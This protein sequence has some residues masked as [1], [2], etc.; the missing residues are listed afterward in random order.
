[1]DITKLSFE[2]AIKEWNVGDKVRVVSTLEYGRH[3]ALG[4]HF[5]WDNVMTDHKG[6]T[7]M[8]ESFN[9]MYN[10]IILTNGT[11]RF[12]NYFW[13]AFVL[14]KVEDT[15]YFINT[16][17]HLFYLKNKEVKIIDKSTRNTIQI[18]Y[19]DLIKALEELKEKAGDDL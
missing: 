4:Y 18:K 13:P 2:K 6:E 10:T 9:H 3:D 15:E 5:C 14:E 7:F 8:I 19:S 12:N 16:N 1:M 11:S 17:N